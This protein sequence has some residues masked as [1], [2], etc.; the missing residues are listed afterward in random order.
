MI[1]R[2]ELEKELKGKSYEYDTFSKL[3]VD[4]SDRIK[5]KV[6]ESLDLPRHKLVSFVT[7]GQ[8]RDQGVRV[9]SRCVWNPAWDHY[10]SASYNNHSVFAV[11]VVFAAYFE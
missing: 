2:T 7:I 9:G 8:M 5:D 4:L 11:G 3:T 10:A 6:K 1:I